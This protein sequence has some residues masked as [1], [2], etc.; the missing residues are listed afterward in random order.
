LKEKIEP[1]EYT[2]SIGEI[3]ILDVRSDLEFSFIGIDIKIKCPNAIECGYIKK[4]LKTN[5]LSTT[6]IMD[7]CNTEKHINCKRYLYIK[8]NEKKPS[9]DMTPEGK[10]IT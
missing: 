7:Y 4:Y 2:T 10:I 8:E 3:L 1:G 9:D 5:R 6:F